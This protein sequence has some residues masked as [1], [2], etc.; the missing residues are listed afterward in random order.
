MFRPELALSRFELADR[1]LKHYPQKKS[2]AIVQLDFVI[3]F[4]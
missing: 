4:S 2:E 1:L 3:A